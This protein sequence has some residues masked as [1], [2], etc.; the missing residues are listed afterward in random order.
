MNPQQEVIILLRKELI[1][2]QFRN[3]AYS[4]RA[5][6]RKLKTSPSV[7]SEILNGR[8]PITKKTGAKILNALCIPESKAEQ[9]LA[10][11]PQRNMK[12]KTKV[13][14]R[15]PKSNFTELDM[16]QFDMIANWYYFAILSL[17]ETNEFKSDISWIA[18]RLGIKALEAKKA[19]ETL[20]KF[21]L[22]KK[23]KAGELQP[24]GKQFRTASDV[25]SL[26]MR[27]NHL[28]H[29]DLLRDSLEKDPSEV[30]DFSSITLTFDP[31]Q[32][33]KAK[34]M[35]KDFRRVFCEEVEQ[36]AK[37]EVYRLS[38]QFVPLSKEI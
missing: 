2:S 12:T 29:L 22:L 4:M 18:K 3:S 10:E 36:T 20:I 35:I 25:N 30:R 32:M 17:A 21:E 16:T 28:Q 31:T 7:V 8:R 23:N 9:I 15:K 6:A 26:S 1:D 14:L 24:T 13:L 37:Q 33:Q 27:R 19:I 5:L 38:I 11:L 34:E